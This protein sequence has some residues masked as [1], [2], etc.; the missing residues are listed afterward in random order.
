M[1]NSLYNYL[2]AHATTYWPASVYNNDEKLKEEIKTITSWMEENPQ[3]NEISSRISENTSVRT[4]QVQVLTD[5][6]KY[7]YFNLA[8]WTIADEFN[9]AIGQGDNAYTPLQ[10]ARYIATLGNDAGIY[11]CAKMI[12]NQ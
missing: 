5:L 2:Y 8:E 6:I 1:K 7:S 3:R 10:M 11:G 4:G 9:I 12:L